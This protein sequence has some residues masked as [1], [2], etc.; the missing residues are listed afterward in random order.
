MG[1]IAN[2]QEVIPSAVQAMIDSDLTAMW[3]A[4]NAAIA[5]AVLAGTAFV[6]LTPARTLNTVF[7]PS[8]TKK[9]FVVYVI[10]M[11]CQATI[12]SGGQ[13]AMARIDTGPQNPPAPQNASIGNANEVSLAVAVGVKNTQRATLFAWV[14]PG[15]NVRIVTTSSGGPTITLVNSFEYIFG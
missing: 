8:A 12:L 13:S 10:E 14:Q 15:D 5:A 3:P 2:F 6:L 4:I 9:S 1:Q 7:Q 11:I